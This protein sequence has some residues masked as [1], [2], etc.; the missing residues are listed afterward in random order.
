MPSEVAIVTGGGSGIGAALC[1]ELARRGVQVVVTDIR[2]AGAEHV[3]AEI[4]AGGGQAEPRAVDVS[5]QFAVHR[6]VSET[7]AAYGRLDFLFNNAGMAIGGDARDLTLEHWRQVLDVDLFGVL[8]GCL[9]AYPVMAQQGFGNIVNTSSAAGFIPDPGNGPYCTA[10]HALIG[11]SLSLRLEGADLG[12][13]VSVVCP[14]LVRSNIYQN[15]RVINMPGLASLRGRD[16][17]RAAGAPDR[18][19]P[20][21]RAAR[22]ILDGVARNEAVIVFP[23]NVRWARRLY[24]VLPGLLEREMQRRWY[25]LRNYRIA[26]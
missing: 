20:A 18:M 3:A 12:V 21:D 19:M 9:A 5:D 2:V 13:K 26:A 16:R 11:L 7:V 15:A 14:G 10:K 23:A 8:H 1:R 22:G 17:E 6:L 24:A 25:R 4:V